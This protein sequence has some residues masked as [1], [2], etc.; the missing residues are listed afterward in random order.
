MLT[1]ARQFIGLNE[2]QRHSSF[3]IPEFKGR[4]DFN[5]RRNHQ[6][7]CGDGLPQAL[8]NRFQVYAMPG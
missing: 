3:R 1:I 8:G 7:S 2:Q 6:C 4:G 5:N